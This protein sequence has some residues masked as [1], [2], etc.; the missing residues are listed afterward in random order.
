MMPGASAR[1]SK[2]WS[3]RPCSFRVRMKRSMTP[4]HWGSPTNDGVCVLPSQARSWRTRRPPTAAPSR[5]AAHG[6]V[7]A[8]QS[9]TITGLIDH[10]F[11]WGFTPSRRENIGPPSRGQGPRE[12]GGAIP[13]V[14]G[15]GP[16]RGGRCARNV[17]LVLHQ[18]HR[19]P[20]MTAVS[21][22]ACPMT[23]PNAC[24]SWPLAPGGAGPSTSLRPS[25][26]T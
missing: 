5:S 7:A 8:G 25:G 2:R 21:P 9:F 15:L 6:S 14:R 23:S 20:D 13:D 18:A 10:L 4:W 26:N 24:A 11:D 12:G 1:V 22:S 3:Q 16:R 19:R 17:I